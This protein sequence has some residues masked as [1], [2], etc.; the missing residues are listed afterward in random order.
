MATGV[1]DEQTALATIRGIMAK[2]KEAGKEEGNSKGGK[3]NGGGKEDSNGERQ[4]Q[5]PG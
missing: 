3:S 2:T 4:Q 5:Q 1:V